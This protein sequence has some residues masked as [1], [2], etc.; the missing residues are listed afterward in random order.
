MRTEFVPR[1]L[2]SYHNHT[3]WSDGKPT[4]AEQIAAARRLELDE[5]GISDH[6]VL[7][8]T[9]SIGWSMAVD[10]FSEYIEEL[11][12]AAAGTDEL[13]LRIGVEADYFPET[14][15]ALGDLLAGHPLD[16]VIGSVHFVDGFP[17]DESA[18]LWDALSA[19]EVEDVWRVY[20]VR[21]AEL[22]RSGMYDFLAHPDL[23]KKFGRRQK[24]EHSNEREA[25]LRAIAS[26]G[27]AIEINT[28]GWHK[29]VRE[30]YP[31]LDLLLCA[32]MRGIP[33]LIN[34]DAHETAHLTR[35]FDRG[36]DL[37]RLAGYSELVQYDSR[38]SFSY[39]F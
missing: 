24:S 32:R 10:R 9:A 16:F 11:Q 3:T 31:T 15:D 35:D 30:A 12:S 22:A 23:P 25:A 39:A 18:G 13:K 36:F 21:V 2:T 27:M 38:R 33:L 34:S 8:P 37:A 6:L 1:M 26:S 28:A 7:H 5:L 19:G 17:I 29:P 4:V 14:V 20:W